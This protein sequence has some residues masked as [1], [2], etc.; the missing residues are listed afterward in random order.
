MAL[1]GKI[2]KNSWL[3]I[4]LIGLG[5]G[6]FVIMDMFSGQQSIFGS[7]Q[8]VMGE[9]DGKVVDINEFNRAEGI[10][11]A[12]GSGNNTY[13]NRSSLWNYFVEEAI[14]SSEADAL[15]LGVSKKEL[16]D[17]EF[18]SNDRLSPVVKA[19]YSNPQ[20][21]NA[22]DREQL[23]QIKGILDGGKT[24]MKTMIETGQLNPNF[25]YYWKYQEGE[26]T[27]DRLQ[28]KLINMV[29]KS[30]YTPN[31]MAE[32]IGNNQN[33]KVDFNYVQIPFDKI[34]DADVALADADYQ[35]YLDQ[36]I[37]KYTRDEETRKV[38][39]VEFKVT[40][41]KA[42]STKL[43]QQITDL[44]EGF[45][46]T[47]DDSIFVQNNFGSIS[48][49]W[50]NG[51]ALNDAI[52]ETVFQ[53]PVGSVYGPYLDGNSFKAVK[54]LD[55][56]MIPD[57]A[58]SRHILI[59]ATDAA[60]FAAATKTIDS[61]KTLLLNGAE[62]DTLAAKFSQDPGSAQNGGFYD[63]V[64]V[65]QFVPEFND[66]IFYSGNIGSLYS[67]R[68][69]F[70]VHLIEPMGRKGDSNPM[71]RVA[72]ISQNIEPSEETQELVQED[73][74]AFLDANPTMESMIKSATEQGFV[75]ETSPSLTRNDFA[76]G[77]LGAGNTSR[78]IVRW[79][80]NNDPNN[81]GAE[82][83]SVSPQVYGFQDPAQYFTN[84]YVVVGLKNTQEAG[85]PSVASIKDEIELEVLNMKK[86]ETII[87][88]LEGKTDLNAIAG[89]YSAK[90]DTA[91]SI[92]FSGAFI[93]N[94]GNEPAVVASAL[95]LDI[96]TTSAPIVGNN[97]VYVVMPTYK[98]TAG[99]VAN[100]PQL[101]QNE[102]NSAR[103]QVRARLIQAMRKR[104]D[105]EDNRARFF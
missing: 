103:A 9:I 82:V 68:T 8:S 29:E 88:Q 27:K 26:I 37:A 53:M 17:L 24:Q 41:S 98:P 13:G 56:Q 104:A 35:K 21:P 51:D 86:G 30:M 2:R 48:Q 101:R 97:G 100:I 16:L 93:P 96:N 52:A 105:V 39:Y 43:Q 12:G 94:V 99:T 66:I 5:L 87:A 95:N 73:A 47:D 102:Q 84:K 71:V 4:V 25:P 91:K 19:R 44:K 58:K 63:Y 15:G 11:Y 31:W 54:I 70:G 81:P 10:L 59:S 1:I 46:S 78:E 90:V 49:F 42:D 40:P 85:V 6:G 60:S 23:N 76:V 79:A 20:N 72:Y 22:V 33:A 74:I 75:I 65:N 50:M 34:D 3:L 61:L 83:G 18:G 55:R 64:P 57:S 80:F 32:M 67:V 28:S 14:V 69:Q 36:N 38:E 45:A 62:F 77:S 92:A 89:Q 7:Q